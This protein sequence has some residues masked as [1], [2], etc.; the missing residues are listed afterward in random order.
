MYLAGLFIHGL[1]IWEDPVQRAAAL[2]VGL[3]MLGLTTVLARRGTFAGSGPDRT[4]Y[5]QVER[6]SG[7]DGHAEV[8]RADW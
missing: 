6:H 1:V 4:L 7:Q 3:M 2:A 5:E 8:V